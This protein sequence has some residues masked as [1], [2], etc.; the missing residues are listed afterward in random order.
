M[1]KSELEAVPK[2][3]HGLSR[4]MTFLEN[5]TF[6]FFFPFIFISW[7]LITLQYCSGFLPYIDMNQP[8]IYMC[9]PSQS[10]LPRTGHF[11]TSI[12][13]SIPWFPKNWFT[14]WHFYVEINMSESTLIMLSEVFTKYLASLLLCHSA[15]NINYQGAICEGKYQNRK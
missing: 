14:G 15:W 1:S 2:L 11:K 8:W 12:K 13:E 9:S 5:W 4:L 6:Y 10:P 3:Y 7:R